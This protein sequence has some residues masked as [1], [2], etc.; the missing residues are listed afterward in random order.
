MQ[1]THII[2]SHSHTSHTTPERDAPVGKAS[3]PGPYTAAVPPSRPGARGWPGTI[4]DTAH[5]SVLVHQY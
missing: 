3:G 4:N 2:T 1:H 5:Q